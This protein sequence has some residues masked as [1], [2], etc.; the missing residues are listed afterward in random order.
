MIHFQML[1]EFITERPGA[2]LLSLV[3]Y[4]IIGNVW[5]GPI[6]GKAWRHM[7]NIHVKGKPTMRSMAPA[8][9]TSLLTAFVQAVVLGRGMQILAIQSWVDPIIIAT[10]LWFPFTAMTMAT[11][12]AY[13]KKPFKLLLID[14]LFVLATLWATSLVIYSTAL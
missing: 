4:M 14:S 9:A 6:F 5:Y 10:I 13:L 2:I 7:N 11:S 3:V 12:Y 8:M 1:G